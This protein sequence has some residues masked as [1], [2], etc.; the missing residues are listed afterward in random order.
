MAKKVYRKKLTNSGG[1]VCVL[2]GLAAVFAL[3]A[4]A[5]DHLAGV[6]YAQFYKRQVYD[7]SFDPLE[8]IEGR[9][10][11]IVTAVFALIMFIWALTA[12]K[13]KKMGREFGWTGI[14]MGL[15]LSIEP[16]LDLWRKLEGSFISNHFRTDYDSDK[17][18][19][20]VEL[21]KSGLPMLACVF[22]MLAGLAVLIKAGGEDFVLEAPRAGRKQKS[23]DDDSARSFGEGTQ[24]V[25]GLTGETKPA[26]YSEKPADAEEVPATEPATE[27][28]TMTWEKPAKKPTVNLCPEC[29]ELVGV[30]ELFC[31]NCGHKM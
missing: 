11:A 4:A 1:G 22:I 23:S 20:A 18:R 24:E 25:Q 19:G 31:S 12:A 7:M 13:G 9:R 28:K 10:C 5:G 15:S 29:G 26:T 6:V 30:D 14:F 16:V 21:A 3:C 2:T 17:F 27:A 8:L